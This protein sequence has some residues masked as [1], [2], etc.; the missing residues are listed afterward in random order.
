MSKN[1]NESS[2]HMLVDADMF[3]YRACSSCEREID[4]GNDLW[5]LHVDFNEALA[6]LM[7]NMDR[8]IERALELYNY[9]GE[10]DVVYTFSDDNHN[11]RKKILPTYKL[12]R[13]GK[14]KPVAYHALKQWVKDNCVSIEK[15]WLEAD[16]LLGILATGK[17]KGH[18]IVMSADKD[19]TTIPTLVYNFLKDTLDD[20]SPE[21]AEHKHL[22]QTL[23]G[24]TADNYTGCKGVGPKT[25]DRI[26]EDGVDWDTVV[27]AFEKHNMTKEDALR[28]ARVAKILLADNFDIKKGKIKLWTP[29]RNS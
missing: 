2:M 8:W 25:A 29:K 3:V 17:Y 5:T 18:N 23:V 13:V 12:N 4:W 19:M 1:K 27:S 7:D 6:Y 9:D 15:P 14:R 24:D 26:L 21:Q 11:F 22:W 28:Q 20:V 10:F 16:D